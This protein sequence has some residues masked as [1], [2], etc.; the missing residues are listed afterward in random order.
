MQS[1][2]EE[3]LTIEMKAVDLSLIN[4]NIQAFR[5]YDWVKVISKPHSII[6]SFFLLKK[7]EINLIDPTDSYIQLGQ[8]IKGIS[9]EIVVQNKTKTKVE[10]LQT[11]LAGVVGVVSDVNQIA[12]NTVVVVEE[13]S[14]NQQ[15]TADSLL[16][17]TINMQSLI[18]TVS[19]N[20][21]TLSDLSELMVSVVS[22]IETQKLRID[23]LKKYVSMEV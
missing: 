14:K 2:I 9:D 23:K 22:D 21:K 8:I 12:N 3:S 13:I 11:G 19:N 16:E 4:H 1:T 7:M 17:L 15:Q 5:M 18:E 6:K 20:T 10:T